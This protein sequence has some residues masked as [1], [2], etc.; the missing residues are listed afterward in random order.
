MSPV[1]LLTKVPVPLPSVVLKDVVVGFS[2]VDQ[3]TPRD[4][5]VAPP[6]EETTP[7][8][9]AELTVISLKE[10]VVTC[11]A[12]AVVGFSLGASFL[13]H[14]NAMHKVTAIAKTKA[15]LFIMF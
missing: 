7:P 2:L 13:L 6:S 3:Q 14:D 15:Y 4:D 5:T 9:F 11:G 1:I 8:H 10:E 12:V